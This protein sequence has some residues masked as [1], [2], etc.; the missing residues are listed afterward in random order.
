M[1]AIMLT[2]VDQTRPR[3]TF[4]L[5]SLP[6]MYLALSVLCVWLVV[7]LVFLPWDRQMLGASSPEGQD[8][9]A[10]MLETMNAERS[11]VG[12]PPLSLGYSPIAQAHALDMYENCYLSHYDRLGQ[13]P[14]VRHSLAG[15]YRAMAENLS[16]SN[17]CS[18]REGLYGRV[19]GGANSLQHAQIAM[20]SFLKSPEHTEVLRSPHYTN[21]SIGV[22]WDRYNFYTAHIFEGPKLIEM[23]QLPAIDED[24]VLLLEGRLVNGDRFMSPYDL[25][26]QIYFDP[27]PVPPDKSQLAQTRC[28]DI[29]RLV[30][31][32]LP[33]PVRESEMSFHANFQPCRSPV[34]FMPSAIMD[35][36][37]ID[38]HL[39]LLGANGPA[40]A[41]QVHGPWVVAQEWHMTSREFS[42]STDL[43]EVLNANGSG[44]YTIRLWGPPGRGEYAA[45]H[46]IIWEGF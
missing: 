17:V 28:Y 12:S 44:V 41:I 32:V 15:G 6:Y 4:R 37:A 36:D 22:A 10:Y 3:R 27:T 25:S 8:V 1:R 45:E 43:S 31:G 19:R 42:V 9:V 20:G 38:R 33:L 29:G 35:S 5:A 21:V 26:V 14:Y 46:S 39:D 13:K 2:P 24:G 30:A 16:G 11:R 18:W 23:T 40:P 34:E 7:G